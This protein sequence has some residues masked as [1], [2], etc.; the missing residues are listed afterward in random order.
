MKSLLRFMLHYVRRKKYQKEIAQADAAIYA[1]AGFVFAKSNVH[2][3]STLALV[4]ATL[5]LAHSMS[6]SIFC[7][8]YNSR[9]AAR[10][11]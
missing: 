4:A 2:E 7:K 9:R 8:W 1:I 11:K 5:R 3:A 6:A 10:K